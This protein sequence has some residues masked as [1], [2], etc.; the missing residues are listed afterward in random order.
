MC[1]M[2]AVQEPLQ[3]RQLAQLWGM[4]DERTASQTTPNNTENGHV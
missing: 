1:D 4:V 2:F 3:D